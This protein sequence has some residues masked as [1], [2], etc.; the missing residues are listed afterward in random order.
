[1]ISENKRRWLTQVYALAIKEYLQIF[2]DITLMVFMVYAFTGDVYFA[3]SGVTLQLRNA[4]TIVYDADRSQAS[5]DLVR[6]FRPPYFSVEDAISMPSFP[7]SG[8]PSR[9]GD[10]ELARGDAMISLAIPHGFE[11]RLLRDESQSLQMRVDTT[12]SIPGYLASMYSARIVNDFAMRSSPLLS[13]LPPSVTDFFPPLRDEYRTLFNPNQDEGWFMSVSQLL[14]VITVFAILLPGAAL[15]RERERGTIEQLTVSPLSPF[16]ILLP[17]VFAMTSIVLLG[18]FLSWF[19]VLR[20]VFHVPSRGGFPLF[21]AVTVL[22]VVT[23]TSLG[24][25]AATIARNMAQIG[26]L[27]IFLVAPMIFLSGAW[28]PPEAMP[29]WLRVGTLAFPLHHYINASYAILFK[30]AGLSIIWPSCLAIAGL[31]SVNVLF[32]LRRFRGI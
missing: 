3:G 26:M 7:V 1:M 10:S 30:G 27:T 23:S 2:R 6:Q 15:V 22:Y 5:R 19:F 29:A 18:T 14:N 16:Q 21:V 9:G 4:A 13:Q 25:L 32:T 17:K 28:T 20:P 11:R 12:H 31:G 24:L 8:D